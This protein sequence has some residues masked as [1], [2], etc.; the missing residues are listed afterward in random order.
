M[1]VHQQA[2]QQLQGHISGTSRSSPDAAVAAASPTAEHEYAK[3]SA[4]AAAVALSAAKAS[5]IAC[6]QQSKARRAEQLYVSAAGTGYPA[7]VRNCV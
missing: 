3:G 2:Q 6:Q 1:L 4:A 7:A 5:A